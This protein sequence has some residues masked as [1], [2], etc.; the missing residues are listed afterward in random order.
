MIKD[1]MPNYV[2]T[3]CRE[4]FDY[5]C[6]HCNHHVYC[7]GHFY[8]NKDMYKMCKE[9]QRREEYEKLCNALRQ[10]EKLYGSD[11]IRAAVMEV[12]DGGYL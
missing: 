8:C 1:V 5:E 4:V 6:R 7:D 2:N 11:D 10:Y 3:F 9:D 12:V